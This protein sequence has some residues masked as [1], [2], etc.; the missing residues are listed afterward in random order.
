[1]ATG[2]P[3]RTQVIERLGGEFAHAGYE[4][5]DVII[6]TRTDPPRIVV[7][8]DGDVPPDLDA[9][10]ELSRAAS[11]L[12]DGLDDAACPYVLEV[13]SPGAERV[14]SSEKHFR[15]AQ[16]RKV[17]VELTDGSQLAARVG[18][19]HG[20]AVALVVRAGNRWAVRETLLSEIVKAVV[21]IEFS[22][23]NRLEL[24]LASGQ[25]AGA[26]AGT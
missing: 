8:I 10:A 12:L 18:Q 26:E 22:M 20:N 1:M 2:L 19:L 3:S 21:Q 4:I 11:A 5:D 24:E 6:D 16:G 17:Q 13:S 14:L 15:R 9:I 23:P 25:V 7:T